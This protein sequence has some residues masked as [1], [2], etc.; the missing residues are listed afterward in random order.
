ML[1]MVDCGA[2]T[3]YV[4]G[5]VIGLPD[6]SM[7][8]P[9]SM[10]PSIVMVSVYVPIPRVCGSLNVTVM[11]STAH[12]RRRSAIGYRSECCFPQLVVGAG[13]G[14]DDDRGLQLRLRRR[15]GNACGDR[16]VAGV[17]DRLA[18][19]LP[20]PVPPPLLPVP[21]LAPPLLPPPQADSRN[22]A[23]SNIAVRHIDPTNPFMERPLVVILASRCDSARL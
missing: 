8:Q 23:P 7:V 12:S 18:C 21:V 1:L 20:V 13:R 14:R 19:E 6:A 9:S 22:A 16:Q 3:L 2:V 11:S 5:I 4:T 17:T 15:S 10:Q